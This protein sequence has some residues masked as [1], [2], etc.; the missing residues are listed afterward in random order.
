M[1]HKL[2][3]R[4]RSELWKMFM[5]IFFSQFMTINKLNWKT[6]DSYSPSAQFGL[7]LF[8]DNLKLIFLS[9]HLSWSF[10]CVNYTKY[11]VSNVYIL[12]QVQVI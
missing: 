4:A 5:G 8:R 3:L 2:L 11:K 10:S 9:K 6:T 12:W 1:L 7:Y